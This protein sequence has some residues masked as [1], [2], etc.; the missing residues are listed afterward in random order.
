MSLFRLC[1]PW[2]PEKHQYKKSQQTPSSRSFHPLLNMKQFVPD[3]KHTRPHNLALEMTVSL[4]PRYEKNESNRGV[5]NRNL[6][7]EITAC[8]SQTDRHFSACHSVFYVTNVC[9][10]IIAPLINQS[11]IRQ[12]AVSWL[13]IG[14]P[15]ELCMIKKCTSG[16]DPVLAT[17]TR[18]SPKTLRRFTFLIQ[19]VIWCLLWAP[20]P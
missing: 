9:S 6:Q 20:A 8:G 4:P 15:V 5:M 17:T 3:L 11:S 2:S 13:L 14:S 7:V 19:A 16:A 1:R 12:Q 10:G 18:T